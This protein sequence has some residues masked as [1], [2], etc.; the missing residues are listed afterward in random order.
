MLSKMKL[1]IVDSDKEYREALAQQIMLTS[2][3]FVVS[4][5]DLSDRAAD[6][7]ANQKTEAGDH[8]IVLY[9]NAETFSVC[10]AEP[11]PEIHRY[12]NTKD[13]SSEKKDRRK[14]KYRE[15][16]PKYGRVS[17]L[18]AELL[19]LDALHTG[20][21]R[22]LPYCEKDDV[23]LTGFL[24]G[25]GGTGKTSAALAF[26]RFLAREQ[27]ERVLYLSLEELNGADFYLDSCQRGSLPKPPGIQQTRRSAG[28]AGQPQFLDDLLYYFFSRKKSETGALLNAFLKPDPYG[29]RFVPSGRFR[30]EL[31][32]LSEAELSE[33]MEALCSSGQFR[34]IVLDL[35]LSLRDEMLLLIKS[36]HA[37]V[38]IH[39]DSPYHHA[40]HQRLRELLS[41]I[42]TDQDRLFEIKTEWEPGFGTERESAEI[43]HGM[44]K[45]VA[46]LAERMVSP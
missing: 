21:N 4:A 2:G 3:E 18:V 38:L 1:L 37:L 14:I 22:V 23:R 13:V 45:E 16:F 40:R 33:W 42:G 25:S 43:Y 5:A 28:K 31:L 20:R 12:E 17:E 36:C 30:N 46:A 10:M 9:G 44:G 35:P 29:V 6:R 11:V 7:T 41:E 27:N 24:S 15:E 8:D 32:S 26:A 34:H 19:L 39:A